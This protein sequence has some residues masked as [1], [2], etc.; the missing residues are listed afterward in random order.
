VNKNYSKYRLVLGGDLIYQFSADLIK[1]LIEA[2]VKETG[3]RNV[4]S[5]VIRADVDN[6]AGVMIYSCHFDSSHWTGR[7]FK[8][9]DVKSL[10]EPQTV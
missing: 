3:A 9:F 8:G 6:V 2:W 4:S 1:F 5:G 10:G 7:N